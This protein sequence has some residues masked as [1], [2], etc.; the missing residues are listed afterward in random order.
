MSSSERV[1]GSSRSSP[2]PGLPILTLQ[3]PSG[4]EGFER[5]SRSAFCHCI[6][7]PQKDC[8]QH[9]QGKKKSRM[10]RMKKAWESRAGVRLFRY[11]KFLFVEQKRPKKMISFPFERANDLFRQ[12]TDRSR[13]FVTRP[14]GFLELL[15]LALW[16]AWQRT[17]L[18]ISAFHFH[19]MKTFSGDATSANRRGGFVEFMPWMP[20]WSGQVQLEFKCLWRS[21]T[22]DFHFMA[23]NVDVIDF[24]LEPQTVKKFRCVRAS[25][26]FSKNPFFTRFDLW[27][28]DSKVSCRE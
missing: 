5:L 19:D 26:T 25:H 3:S 9:Q 13:A 17:E 18:I 1:D 8:L 7:Q 20:E 2:P 14:G 27:W 6:L 12:N 22:R 28:Q 4:F 24:C 16:R 15:S 10:R 21:H 11:I 23:S